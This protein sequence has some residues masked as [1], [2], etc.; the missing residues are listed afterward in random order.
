MKDY[1][2]ILRGLD[3]KRLNGT[4]FIGKKRVA[5]TDGLT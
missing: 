2:R 3:C 1:S 4:L 5:L